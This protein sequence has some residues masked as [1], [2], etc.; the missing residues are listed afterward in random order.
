MRAKVRFNAD[1][2][3]YRDRQVPSACGKLAYA[4]KKLAKQKAAEQTRFSGEFIEAY[5]CYRCHAHHIGHPPKP[6]DYD[7]ERARARSAG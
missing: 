5:H 3:A 4:S 6:Y 7:A 2:E 1:G